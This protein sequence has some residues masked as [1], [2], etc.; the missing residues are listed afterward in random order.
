MNETLM[1][2][3]MELLYVVLIGAIP[4]ISKYL[5]AQIDTKKNEILKDDKTKYF[6]DSIDRAMRLVENAVDCVSQTYVDTLK[7]EGK[8]DAEAQKN[9]YN[10]A[11]EAI[12]R[13]M[14]DDM[15]QVLTSIYGDLTIWMKVTIEAYIKSQK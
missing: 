2:L 11:V 5:I 15:K 13:L 12:T 1:N 10:Q 3:L 14:D 7:K 8:F 4:I 9:A 6:Q